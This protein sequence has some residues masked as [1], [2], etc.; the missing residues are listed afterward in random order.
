MLFF[1]A[2]STPFFRCNAIAALNTYL[3]ARACMNQKPRCSILRKSFVWITFQS[4]KDRIYKSVHLWI[5]LEQRPKLNYSNQTEEKE[6]LT[7]EG[8]GVIGKKERA[9]SSRHFFIALFYGE[10]SLL[11]EHWTCSCIECIETYYRYV[12]RRQMRECKV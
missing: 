1:N 10:R 4:A 2:L 5:V 12:V 3:T 7:V 6:P 9:L 8:W 11:C